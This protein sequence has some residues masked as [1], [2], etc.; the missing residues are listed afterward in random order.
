MPGARCT[1]YDPGAYGLIV[2]QGH[3][4]IGK[5]DIDCPSLIRFGQ[6][7]EDEV[8]VS[9]DAAPQGVDIRQPIRDGSTGESALLRAGCAPGYACCG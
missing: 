6:M 9:H 2:T 3:G 1:I 8:F 4:Q 5:L 7:T